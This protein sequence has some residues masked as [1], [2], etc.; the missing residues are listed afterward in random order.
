MGSQKKCIYA[1][2][3]SEKVEF[4][5]VKN[6][7]LCK[8]LNDLTMSIFRK[9]HFLVLSLFLLSFLSYSRYS[10][11]VL[12]IGELQTNNDEIRFTLVHSISNEF[13]LSGFERIQNIQILPVLK[14]YTQGDSFTEFHKAL[15]VSEN[16]DNIP[17]VCTASNSILLEQICKFQI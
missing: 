1:Y 13:L 8:Y 2:A 14:C 9:F 10:F 4:M 11:Q 15:S 5:V 17:I 3:N 7:Y 16:F 6:L 12:T